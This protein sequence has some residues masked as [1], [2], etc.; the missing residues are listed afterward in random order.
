MYIKSAKNGCVLEMEDDVVRCNPI[1]QPLYDGQLWY[2][3][4]QPDGSFQII[5]LQNGKALHCGDGTRFSPTTDKVTVQNPNDEDE[6]LRW[7]IQD[8]HI[9]SVKNDKVMLVIS[10]ENVLYVYALPRN[11]DMTQNDRFDFD[12]IEFQK[13]RKKVFNMLTEALVD[14]KALCVGLWMVYNHYISS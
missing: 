4:M 5:S 2:K 6:G 14:S 1:R 10:K 11:S 3:A 7:T 8:G 9:Q 13:I 12:N